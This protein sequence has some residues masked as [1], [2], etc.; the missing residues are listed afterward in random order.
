MSIKGTLLFLLLGFSALCASGRQ[1]T[2]SIIPLPQSL[3]WSTDKFDLEKC[4]TI[5][6]KDPSL[7]REAVRLQQMLAEK[8]NKVS[9]AQAGTPKGYAIEL[10]LDT[11]KAGLLR[12][13]AYRL[14]VMNNAIT[15]AANTGHGIFNGLQ[16]LAQL[17]DGNRDRKSTRL[18]SSHLAVSRMPSSA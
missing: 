1:P 17:M 2:P 8:G 12:E 7:K 11:V 16:T 14:E 18:N 13:E 5:I 6:I 9:I 15:L 10:K 3:Q 4:R